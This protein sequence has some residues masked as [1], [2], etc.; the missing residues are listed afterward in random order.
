VNPDLRERVLQAVQE[1]D[2]RPNVAARTLK[3]SRSRLLVFIV[4]EITN[5]YYTETYRG[6]HSVAEERGYITLMDETADVES[7][8][9]TILARDPDGLI[10]DAFHL[11][12][13]KKELLRAEIPFVLTNAAADRTVGRSSVKIDIS[14]LLAR[15]STTSARWV[16]S[17]SA[18]S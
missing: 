17:E 15:C 3:T 16:T 18:S 8:L 1:L 14:E 13:T 11:G 6:I 12:A 9:R 4:P 7:S 2:Y 5:P 10:L